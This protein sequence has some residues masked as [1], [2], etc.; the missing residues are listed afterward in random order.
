MWCWFH[1]FPF[2]RP[3]SRSKV[4][5]S[6]GLSWTRRNINCDTTI[7]EKIFIA[8]VTLTLL[9]WPKS[10]KVIIRL[11]ELQRNRKTNAFSSFK[12]SNETI[13]SVPKQDKL[14]TN[15]WARS[16]CVFNKNK[17]AQQNY[18]PWYMVFWKRHSATTTID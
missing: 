15:G 16:K 4:G 11:L 3:I 13:A 5:N 1:S 7:R 8:K 18:N 14:L 10:L 17:D 9:R 2:S 12:Q 6:D